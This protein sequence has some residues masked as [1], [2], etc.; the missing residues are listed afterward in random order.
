MM[1][2]SMMISMMIFS[3]VKMPHAEKEKFTAK[4]GEAGDDE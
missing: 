3:R 2:T 1:M 4:A